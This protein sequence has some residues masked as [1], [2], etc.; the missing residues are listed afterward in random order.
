VNTRR[1]VRHWFD[2]SRTALGVVLLLPACSLSAAPIS[3]MT[4]APN[5]RTFMVGRRLD[6]FFQFSRDSGWSAGLTHELGWTVDHAAWYA[7]DVWRSSASVG[8]AKMPLTYA[9]SVG[10]EARV[11]AG[12]GRYALHGND[13][14]A[15]S[16]GLRLG[17][18]IRTS[19][20]GQLWDSE[21]PVG[22]NFMIVPDVALTGFVPLGPDVSQSPRSELTLGIAFRVHLWTSLLP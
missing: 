20:R 21:R 18:P 14:P 7:P 10:Y 9:P 5:D 1:N 16:G 4:L 19:G 12:M 2:A 6:A 17:L 8:W 13:T 15:A 11:F 22:I 3:G